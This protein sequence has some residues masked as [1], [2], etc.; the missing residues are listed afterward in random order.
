MS[1]DDVAQQVIDT[2]QGKVIIHR[3]NSYTTNSV[4]LKFDYGAANSLRISDHNGKAHL[5]Y[6]YNILCGLDKPTIKQNDG[7]TM[8]FYPDSMV[9]ECCAAI[10]KAKAKKLNYYRSYEAYVNACKTNRR[11]DKGF[12]TGAMEVKA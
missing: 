10:L 7:C 6:K 8:F 12:W 3:Y 1:I 5:K 4:Y 11:T 9:S 2:L